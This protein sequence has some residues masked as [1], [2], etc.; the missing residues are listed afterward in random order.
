MHRVY[1]GLIHI[2]IKVSTCSKDH[3]LLLIM[4]RM[5]RVHDLD[6]TF[7]ATVA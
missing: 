2:D 4:Q 5:V 6:P 3:L 1:T 7:I